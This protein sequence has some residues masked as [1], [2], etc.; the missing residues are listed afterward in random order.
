MVSAFEINSSPLIRAMVPR[1]SGAKLIVSFSCAS[2]IACRNEPAPLSAAFV[3]VITAASEDASQPNAA[4]ATSNRA[5]QS[6]I[7]GGDQ[8]RLVPTA[9]PTMDEEQIG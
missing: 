9:G 4:L 1:T 7:I 3:T 6:V 2:A 5:S 8:R